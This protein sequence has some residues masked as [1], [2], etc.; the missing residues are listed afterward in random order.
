MYELAYHLPHRLTSA[1][2]ALEENPSDEELVLDAAAGST[3]HFAALVRRYS[4]A[5]YRVGYRLCGDPHEAEDIAQ[6]TFVKVF[7][8]L[9]GARLDMPFKPWLYRIAINTAI[10]HLRRRKAQPADLTVDG[11]ENMGNRGVVP[12]FADAVALHLDAQAA[13]N[14]L[15]LN[16]RQVVVL[17]AIEGLGFAE[18]TQILDT[19]EATVRTWFHRAKTLLRARLSES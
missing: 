17:R 18:I 14:S 13:I 3:N 11:P 5:I 6:E 4:S 1:G 15:P 2:R 9:P 7:R 16:Y 10:S 19:P 8:A 12:S